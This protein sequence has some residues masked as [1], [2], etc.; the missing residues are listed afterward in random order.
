MNSQEDLEKVQLINRSEL[1]RMAR[2][3]NID[4]NDYVFQVVRI[5][6]ELNIIDDMTWKKSII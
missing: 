2:R 3:A 4:P 6:P 5:Y 1:Y